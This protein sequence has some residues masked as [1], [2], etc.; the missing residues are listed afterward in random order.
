MSPYKYK[1]EFVEQAEK[2]CELGATDRELSEFFDVSMSTLNLWKIQHKAFAAAL[3]VG[4]AAADE[5]VE[6]SLYRRALGYSF[7]SEKIFND[8]DNGITRTPCV[9]HVPPDITACIFWLKNRRPKEW[10]DMKAIEHDVGDRLAKIAESEL[11]SRLA[12]LLR[13]AG[14]DGASTGEATTH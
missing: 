9:E 4:K 1:P 3:K 2:L 8:K 10:R 5:R 11:E 6:H 13:K 14:V 12:Q 7:D